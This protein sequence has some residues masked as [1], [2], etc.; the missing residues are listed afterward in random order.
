M[1]ILLSGQFVLYQEQ[2]PRPGTGRNRIAELSVA[3]VALG[4]LVGGVVPE[5]EHA[6]GDTA[7]AG[8]TVDAAAGRQRTEGA[9]GDG[10]V[11]DPDTP[12]GSG[13]EERHDLAAG[14]GTAGRIVHLRGG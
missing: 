13:A 14:H 10:K 4:C 1:D 7:I 5:N 2:R 9:G 3:D 12:S 6:D 11:G 8:D